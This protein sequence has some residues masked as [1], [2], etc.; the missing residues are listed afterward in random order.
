MF[1][2]FPEKRVVFITL[3]VMSC[4]KYSIY[5]TIYFPILPADAHTVVDSVRLT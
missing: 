3:S 1:F 2:L 4:F 5:T